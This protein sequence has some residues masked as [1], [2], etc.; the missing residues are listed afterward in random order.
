MAAYCLKPFAVVFWKYAGYFSE[1]AV[2][3]R[4][5]F[6]TAAIT[7]LGNTFIIQ[8]KLTTGM[9]DADFSNIG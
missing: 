9:T 2:K 6:K 4:E 7:D 1:M 5:V 8:H 3:I